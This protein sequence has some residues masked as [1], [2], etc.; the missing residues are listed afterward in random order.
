MRLKT[1]TQDL[2][3]QTHVVASQLI[4]QDFRNMAMIIVANWAVQLALLK[5]HKQLQAQH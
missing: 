2:A 5:A 1:L 3:A 4:G